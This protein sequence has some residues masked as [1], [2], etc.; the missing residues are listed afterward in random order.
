MK[1]DSQN[2]IQKKLDSIVENQKFMQLS[3]RY[4]MEPMEKLNRDKLTHLNDKNG[5]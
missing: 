1:Q 4:E 3:L 2:K 5:K